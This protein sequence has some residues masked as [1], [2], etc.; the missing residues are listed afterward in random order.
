ML[1]FAALLVVIMVGV[2]FVARLNFWYWV[3]PWFDNVSHFLGGLSLGTFALYM[4]YG[5]GIFGRTTPSKREAFATAFVFVLIIGLGWEVFEYVYGIA[6]PSIGQT[7]AQD[8]FTDVFSDICGAAL[9]GLIGGWHT[10]YE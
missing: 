7:Y 3:Y 2:D 1:F 8:T 5:S 9:A 10:W 6:G 4:W